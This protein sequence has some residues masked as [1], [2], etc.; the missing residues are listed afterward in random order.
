MKKLYIVIIIF[1]ASGLLIAQENKNNLETQDV[2][3]THQIEDQ[4][5]KKI[6]EKYP[7][8]EGV[9]PSEQ[10]LKKE[11]SKQGSSANPGGI[12]YDGSR[13]SIEFIK[14]T[15]PN[16]KAK[17]AQPTSAQINGKVA[18]KPL[19]TEEIKATIPKN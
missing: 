11:S 9:L 1:S 7:T 10:G 5:F 12:V 18:V 19:T 14:S 8:T 4:N 2:P 3:K 13:P 17:N 15:I 16:Y 6:N